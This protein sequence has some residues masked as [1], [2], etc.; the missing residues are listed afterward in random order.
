MG[1]YTIFKET[2]RAS[3][4][5]ENNNKETKVSFA[6]LLCDSKNDFKNNSY[7]KSQ[8][9]MLD[10]ALSLA[11]LDWKNYVKKHK[12]I[13]GKEPALN[14]VL[15]Q[16]QSVNVRKEIVSHKSELNTELESLKKIDKGLNLEASPDDIKVVQGIVDWAKEL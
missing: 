7:I 8:N 6:D 3:F 9:D 13:P 4:G 11:S 5:I 12:D 10:T 1:H 16:Q 14:S 2:C 15:N